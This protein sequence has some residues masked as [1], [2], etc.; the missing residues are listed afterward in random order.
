[1][2]FHDTPA[3]IQ[4]PVR[5]KT[6]TLHN[7]RYPRG[8]YS[9]GSLRQSP[10]LVSDTI[11]T[12]TGKI[13]PSPGLPLLPLERQRVRNRLPTSPILQNPPLTKSK[14]LSSDTCTPP[15]QTHQ[16]SA[17]L[18]VRVPAKHYTIKRAAL[19]VLQ[20]R[21]VSEERHCLSSGACTRTPKHTKMCRVSGTSKTGKKKYRYAAHGI[22]VGLHVYTHQ[23]KS[24][25]FA[26]TC[27]C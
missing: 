22:V 5:H 27:L 21:H 15:A 24:K 19:A 17:A 26:D 6:D 23:Q 11:D 20:H 2:E 1:M 14:C 7:G 13:P 3:Q 12:P 4:S 25:I 10:R 8:L 16:P 9:A 18:A